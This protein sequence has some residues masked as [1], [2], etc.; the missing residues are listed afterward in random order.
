MIYLASPYSH[1]DPEVRAARLRQTCR[2]A[3]RLVR[4]GRLVYSPIAHS[5]MLAEQGLPADWPFWAEHSR[6]MLSACRELV[7]LALPGWEEST[8]VK[9]EV[10]IAQGLGLPVRF[11]APEE[12]A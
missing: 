6:W 8:G 11:V 10:E 1:P 5:H 7:V 9:A 2:H 4:K 12:A 3:A